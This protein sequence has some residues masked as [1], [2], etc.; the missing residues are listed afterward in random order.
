[1]I[2]LTNACLL[3]VTFTLMS[4]SSCSPKPE[5][6]VL[7]FNGTIYT[8]DSAFSKVEAIA[9]GDG[10]ILAT[11]TTADLRDRYSF[12]KEIDLDGACVLP[13]LID[14]HCH[15]LGL[16][17]LRREIDLVGTRSPEEILERV[18]EAARKTTDSWLQGRGWD[19]NDWENTSYPT[20]AMLDSA[21][22][23][24]PVI[25]KR[26]D[27]H[28]A[29]VNSRA[30]ALAGIDASTPDPDGG[31]IL[32]GNDG[33]P[34]GILI[35]NAVD[36]VTSIIP[37]PSERELRDMY[38][39][40][41][42]EC[43]S[44]GLTQVHDM[45][46]GAREYEVLAALKSGKDFPL[47]IVAYSDRRDALRQRL[48]ESG[49]VRNDNIG[50]LVAG[51]KLYADG[52]LGSRGA[53][54]SAPYQD[55]PGTRGLLITG[56][57][58]LAAV[59]ER[60]LRRGLQVCVHAIGD[61]ANRVVLDAFEEA[62]RRA[63]SDSARTEDRSPFD[64]AQGCGQ[65]DGCLLRIE[66][67]QV[68]R[69]EDIPRF[70]ALGVIPSMQPTHCTSD[71]YWAEA[72]LGPQRVRGAYAWR[73]LLDTGVII[74]GGS[75]FPVESPN[76]ILGIYAACTRRDTSGIPS[77]QEDIDEH[78]QLPPGSVPDPARW[79]NGWYASQRMTRE[80]AVRAFTIW[81][82]RAAG[83]DNKKGSLE[84]GKAADFV[85][86][87]DDIVAVPAQSIPRIRV[88]E[89]WIDGQRAYIANGR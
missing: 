48:M 29:W 30:L 1:M 58:E 53:Y 78:F 59:T 3:A 16:G 20:A 9:I 68:L 69:P 11:G 80:E 73:S 72:R 77:S 52:A 57:E 35:D 5:A 67:A 60:A 66:H 21:C 26:V 50:L 34:T 45:G 42:R 86:L 47:K 8:V 85:V 88:M 89:T 65:T 37:E 82:A 41:A 22:P 24:R 71:M 81:A 33:I 54:L 17:R 6:D 61:E 56:R 32:R 51:I 28:A 4:L 74:P 14:A 15:L 44:L 55:D 87:S 62:L 79:S 46:I 31:I 43:L 10:K 7:V 23:H 27:G 13:G 83:R 76:P 25:L 84:P 40:A 39:S 70:A 18:A 64:S 12:S 63:V 19:Q 49:P 36:L 2:T 75:D 38:R